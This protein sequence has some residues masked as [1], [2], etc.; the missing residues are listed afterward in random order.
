MKKIADEMEKLERDL[1][2]RNVDAGTIDRQR[3]YDSVVGQKRPKNSWRKIRRKS[4]SGNQGLNPNTP[5][6]I[7]YLKIGWRN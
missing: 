1:L 5:Q 4:Q 7:D 6:N 3:D 2:N